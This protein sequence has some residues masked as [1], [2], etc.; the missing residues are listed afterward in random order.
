MPSRQNHAANASR[1]LAAGSSPVSFHAIEQQSA[2][3]PTEQQ[4]LQA[5]EQL[6]QVLCNIEEL[7]QSLNLLRKSGFSILPQ[8]RRLK[9]QPH[10]PRNR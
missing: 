5:L 1:A 3:A 10:V 4:A 7:H 9:I 6:K 8:S 2:T